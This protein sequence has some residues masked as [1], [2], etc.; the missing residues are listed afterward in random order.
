MQVYDPVQLLRGLS[1]IRISILVAV[2]TVSAVL[3]ILG[4]FPYLPLAAVLLY[5]L[6][7]LVCLRGT[8][9]LARPLLQAS[10]LF[11]VLCLVFIVLAQPLNAWLLQAL[12]RL[13]LFAFIIGHFLLVAGSLIALLFYLSELAKHYE[14]GS[15]GARFRRL[16][17]VATLMLCGPLAVMALM[18]SVSRVYAFAGLLAL[19]FLVIALV[20]VVSFSGALAK[21]IQTVEIKL[22]SQ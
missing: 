2:V 14:Q 21:L 18:V 22:Q 3:V 7:L 5:L 20:F 17:A 1:L 15:L 10:L 4:S 8:G 6:G 16:A 9:T 13:G 11:L 12:G 19:T